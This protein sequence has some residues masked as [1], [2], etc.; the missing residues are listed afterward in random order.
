LNTA[1]KTLRDERL[2]LKNTLKNKSQELG[3]NSAKMPLTTIILSEFLT[4]QHQKR[5]KPD[6]LE[7]S[8]QWAINGQLD[9]RAISAQLIT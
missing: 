3:E 7:P 8:C 5:L 2:T 1:N 9:A 4:L 6:L